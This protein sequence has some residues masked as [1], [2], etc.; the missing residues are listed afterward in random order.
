VYSRWLALTA[1][2]YAVVHHLGLL[3]GGLGAGPDGTRW[4]DWLDLLVPWLVL[5][6]AALTLSADR[7]GPRTWVLF[8]I[9]AGLYLSG[10]GIHLAA[11]SV[12]NAAPSPTAHLWDER[13]GH[14]VWYAGVALVLA[15]LTRTMRGRARPGPW[16]HVLALAVGLTWASNA[17]GGG[18]LVL[19]LVVALPA[20][21][22][23]WRHRRDLPVVLLTGFAPAVAVLAVAAV[24]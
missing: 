7:A 13:V 18:G 16:G 1:L 20:A 15:A 11:N 24:V 10:H 2:A 5:A 17:L 6:P 8:G 3:P 12:G 4:A 9:G 19:G 23:G 22:Y 14:L 21:G